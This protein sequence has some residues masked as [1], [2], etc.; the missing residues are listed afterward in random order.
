MGLHGVSKLVASLQ[1]LRTNCCTLSCLSIGKTEPQS[2][3][4]STFSIGLLRGSHL[5]HIRPI[6]LV[7]YERS[8]SSS[9]QK[10]HLG[11]SFPLRCFQRFS[12]PKVA[13]RH[14]RWHD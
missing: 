4:P 1:G 13:T 7:V 2:V 14:C 3:K 5:F 6:Q 9:D 11:V 8:Y 10:A 12:R